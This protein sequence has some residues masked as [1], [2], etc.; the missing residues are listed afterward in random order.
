MLE[1]A[2]KLIKEG[3]AYVCDT[4][5]EEIEAERKEKKPNPFRERPVE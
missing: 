5:Q 1:F 2:I 3:N 4:S